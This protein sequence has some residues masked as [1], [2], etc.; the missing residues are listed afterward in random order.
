MRMHIGFGIITCL[1]VKKLICRIDVVKRVEDEQLKTIRFFSKTSS[2]RQSGS[3]RRAVEDDQVLLKDEQSKTIRF[4]SKTSRSQSRI[5]VG[6]EDEDESKSK[7]SQS[8]N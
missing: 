3:S 5:Q 1:S 2:R 6:V 7:T 4:F 8:Q